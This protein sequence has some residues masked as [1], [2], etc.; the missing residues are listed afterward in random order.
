MM[1]WDPITTAK[2]GPIMARL[3]EVDII[4]A[5]PEANFVIHLF[6]R[7]VPNFMTGDVNVM[8]KEVDTIT[9]LSDDY[10]LNSAPG[11]FESKTWLCKA[12]PL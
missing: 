5:E 3:G 4:K 7:V 12:L 11:S 9:T 8:G 2:Y 10:Y 6:T 1:S